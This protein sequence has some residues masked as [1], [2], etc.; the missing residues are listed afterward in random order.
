M[1]RFHP[2]DATNRCRL[3]RSLLQNW[4]VSSNANDLRGC[5]RAAPRTCVRR[6]ALM[7]MSFGRRLALI[8]LC[9]LALG[10]L[11]LGLPG[12]G[13]AAEKPADKPLVTPQFEARA[14]RF[15]ESGTET[16]TKAAQG[17]T[18]LEL[19]AQVLGTTADHDLML[20]V[21]PAELAVDAQDAFTRAVAGWTLALHLWGLKMS[22]ADN[23]TAPDINGFDRFLAYAAEAMQVERYDDD[24]MVEAYR[25]QRFLPFDANIRILLDQAHEAF[26][27]GREAILGELE[28]DGGP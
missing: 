26:V 15:I 23:P 13:G 22:G 19:R 5:W 11:G 2:F 10:C 8:L 18:Y 17:G 14:M 20:T 28:A 16:S 24:Y 27:E 6:H 21:W 25:G 12:C 9:G 1:S 3:Q 7:A 4:G